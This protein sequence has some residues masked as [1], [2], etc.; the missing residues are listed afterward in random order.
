MILCADDFGIS[1]SVNEAI[2]E[3]LEVKRL[4]AVSC[5]V[6]DIQNK[7]HFHS[8][9]K[10]S[11][12]IDIGLHFVLTESRRSVTAKKNS[13]ITDYKGNFFSFSNLLIKSFFGKI[14]EEF[15]EK[16]LQAQI[17]I[18]RS[19]FNKDPDF[20][21]GHQHIHQFPVIYN[22]VI[23]K[24]KTTSLKYI[25]IANIP[26]TW[27]SKISF[28]QNPSIYLGNLVIG[29]MAHQLRKAVLLHGIGFNSYLLGHYPYN[30]NVAFSDIFKLY[31]LTSPGP[32]DLFYCHPGKLQGVGKA[33]DVIADA[34]LDCF[35][36]LNS[37]EFAKTCN[38]YELNL[39]TFYI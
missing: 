20:I 27:P 36:F 30:S 15:V 18:F 9:K 11:G 5:M 24:A 10:H 22:V 21:D 34:R 28:I 33:K 23:T 12:R 3:L 16:E 2:L 29:A 6:N 39:N 25:R 35:N 19:I 14:E 31:I 7:D 32:R 8:L 13:C 4:T 1:E 37:D 26:F 17:D 38:K